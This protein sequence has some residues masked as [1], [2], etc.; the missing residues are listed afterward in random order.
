[1]VPRGTVL[2]AD[3][4]RAIVEFIIEALM[5]EGYI[6]S[7]VSD[8]A[9]AVAAILA[10][11]PDLALLDLLLGGMSGLDV[12]RAVRARGSATPMVI[13][14]ADTARAAVL[15]AQSAATCL[16]KPF[17]LDDLYTC[18]AKHLRP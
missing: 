8:G 9:A 12:I 18:V 16:L 2:I 15:E 5:D 4:E 3:D 13:M 1:M 11:A 17:D 14:T 7:G 6:A 10:T